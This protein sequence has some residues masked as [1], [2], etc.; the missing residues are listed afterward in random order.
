M[1]KQD[2]EKFRNEII[3]KLQQFE[4]T[5]EEINLNSFRIHTKPT[6]DYF[7]TRGRMFNLQ[8]LVWSN[9]PLEKF[10]DTISGLKNKP[11][12]PKNNHTLIIKEVKDGFEFKFKTEISSLSFTVNHNMFGLMQDYF[13]KK[14]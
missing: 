10:M 13:S 12:L 6:V 9:V 1:A 8:T 7:P 11:Q 4:I 14:S 2:V 5:V 3:P